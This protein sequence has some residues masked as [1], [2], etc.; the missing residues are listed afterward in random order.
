[1]LLRTRFRTAVVAASGNAGI[2]PATSENQHVQQGHRHRWI[3]CRQRLRLGPRNLVGKVYS[4]LSPQHAL[5]VATATTVRN[6]HGWRRCPKGGDPGD[7]RATPYAAL[8]GGAMTSDA[9]HG[10]GMDP[11]HAQVI[12]CVAEAIDDAGVD[13]AQVRYLNAHG[14]GTPIEGGLTLKTSMGMG[15]CNSAVVVGPAATI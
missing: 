9:L 6:Q 3:G 7:A 13:P 14:T 15:G 1:M 10:T 5:W 2:S 8:L 4:A 11:S 12:R